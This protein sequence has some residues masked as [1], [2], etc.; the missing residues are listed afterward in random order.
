MPEIV[1]KELRAKQSAFLLFSL[2]APQW[3]PGSLWKKQRVAES[4][5]EPPWG[6]D[7][8]LYF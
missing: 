2:L 8:L 4:G 1:I 3:V 6:V 5:Y 7:T